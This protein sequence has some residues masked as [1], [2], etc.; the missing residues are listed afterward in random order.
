MNQ[1]PGEP[2]AWLEGQRCPSRGVSL[3]PFG[4]LASNC[5]VCTHGHLTVLFSR[6]NE[7]GALEFYFHFLQ[8]TGEGT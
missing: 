2:V 1:V 8:S 4:Q 3:T 5:Y 7:V 6:G